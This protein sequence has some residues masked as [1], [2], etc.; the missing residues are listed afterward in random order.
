MI[1]STPILRAVN[2]KIWGPS[3]LDILKIALLGLIIL[4]SG[5]WG[6]SCTANPKWSKIES[7]AP[8]NFKIFKDSKCQGSFH[9]LF[10]FLYKYLQGSCYNYEV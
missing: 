1:I 5:M 2:L 9:L 8:N 10:Q 6:N 7:E 3:T 4:P